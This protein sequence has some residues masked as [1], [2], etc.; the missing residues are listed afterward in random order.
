M[1]SYYIQLIR[2]G[3][4]AGNVGG[5]YIGHTDEELSAE[6]IE[7]INQMKTDYKYPM[8]EAVF[9][10]PLKRCTQTAKLIY[11]N[12]DPIVIDGFIEYNF[13]EFEGKSAEELESHPVFPDWLAGKKGVSP[14]FG[15][16]NEEFS[17]RIAQTMIK[18]IDGIIQ[19]GITKT[20]IVTHGG[21]IMALLSMFGLPEASMHEWLTPGGCGYTIRVTPSLWSQGRKFEVFAQIPEIE[22]ED[23]FRDID[24]DFNVE[25]FLYD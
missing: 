16:S 15:E 6:G 23:E 8:V 11:P 1:K 19:S 9:S 18:V 13:G 24:D 4:T 12:C 2:N 7:Q 25:D 10:S 17:Q 5:R 14:P 22:G 3:L 21:V 20:A